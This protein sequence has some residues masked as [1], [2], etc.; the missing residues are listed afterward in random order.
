MPHSPDLDL[1]AAT[2]LQVG[3]DGTAAPGWLLRQ[4]DDGLGGVVIFARNISGD[5]G[6]LVRRLRQANPRVIVAVDEEG[7][8]V[9]RLQAE[10][11]SSWPG[12]AALGVVDDLERTE[13]TG[14]E[15]GRL[16]GSLGITLD[17]APDADVNAEPENPVIGIRSFGPDAETVARHTAAW[18]TGLQSTG[19][20]ACAKH[21]PGHGDTTTDS[22]LAMPTVHA[23]RDL[24]ERRDLPPFRAAVAAGVRAIMCG[25][26]MVPAL[27][28]ELPASLSRRV[29]TGLL[30]EEMGFQGMIVTDAIEMG[31]VAARLPQP[32]IGV[33]ALVAGADAVCLGI[34]SPGGENVAELRAA[35]VRA[36]HDGTLPEA[37]LAEAAGRVRALA[38]PDGHTARPEATELD[39]RH[40]V[41]HLGLETARLALRITAGVDALELPVLTRPPQVIEM[42]A[43]PHQAI[44][45]H[46]PYGVGEALR[47]RLPGTTRTILTPAEHALPRLDESPCSSLPLVVVTHDAHRHEWMNRNLREI[48]RRRPDA[49]VI[50]TGLPGRS[51]GAVH[52]ATSGNSRVSALAAAEWLTGS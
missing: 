29:L 3:F 37:R 45:A 9:T 35:I 14:R 11:G 33:R 52:I 5:P 51:S 40:G 16:L 4:L 30:R 7:G 25:H 15:I 19:V 10:S 26:L 44:D 1:L 23:G 21:F 43:R 50:E 28:P 17:Y 47:E 12:N 41:S 24:L 27:D 2:V 36:V 22:H 49:I 18:I 31:A 34:T 48:L 6:D 32:M 13:R 42:T 8:S 39:P 20:A 38:S 46:E